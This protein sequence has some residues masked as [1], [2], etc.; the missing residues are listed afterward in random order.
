MCVWVCMCVFWD[1][2]GV[3]SC[4]NA[5]R[6]SQLLRMH[7]LS[8][9]RWAPGPGGLVSRLCSYWQLPRPHSSLPSCPPPPAGCA[10]RWWRRGSPAGRPGIKVYENLTAWE[11]SCG[12]IASS[13]LTPWLL[14][15]RGP[16]MRPRGAPR[17]SRGWGGGAGGVPHVHVCVDLL[18]AWRMLQLPR[19]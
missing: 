2:G 5:A 12:R 3:H 17:T 13:R 19:M 1:G 16:R 8:S 18:G 10:A 11:C 14:H 4:G 7:A 15:S 6:N 9:G